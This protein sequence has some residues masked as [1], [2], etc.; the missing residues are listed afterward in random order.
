MTVAAISGLSPLRHVL[1]N[2]AN[3]IVQETAFSPAVTISAAL[4]AGGLYEPD[5]LTGLAWFLGRVIDRGT[6][7]RSA[8]AI[9]EALDDRGVTLR[10]SV[11]RHTMIVSCT[12][13]A[14][15]FEDLFALIG[16][17]VRGPVFPPAEVEKRRAEIVT[18]IRQDQDN[19]AVRASEALQQ[20]LYGADHPYG[21]PGKGTIE[22]VERITRESLAAFH[23]SRFAPSSLSLV[24]VGEVSQARAIDC[25]SEVFDD[26]TAAEPADRAV[27]PIESAATRRQ[28][29]IPMPDKWRSD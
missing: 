21:R 9:A 8:D 28:S 26:W 15:D 13:L 27:P 3:V 6:A 17:V 1:S 14:E 23:A 5:N 19:P 4:H 12:C 18:A 24:V 7:A 29:F 25:A 11:N 20:L 10:V 2:G 22:T 16:D